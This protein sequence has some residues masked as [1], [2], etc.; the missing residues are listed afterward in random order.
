M[1][2]KPTSKILIYILALVIIG[3]AFYI[4]FTIVTHDCCVVEQYCFPC[5]LVDK[6]CDTLRLFSVLS[7]ATFGILTIL[8]LLISIET[9]RCIY[10]SNLVKLKV[11]MN[12]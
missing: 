11:R 1:N 8:L 2:P 12:N 3:S 4:S 9:V 5:T 6:L 7:N 10:S